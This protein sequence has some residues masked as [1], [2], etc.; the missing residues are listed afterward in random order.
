MTKIS[1]QYSLTNVLTADTTNGRVGINNASPT[2]AL[3]VTGAGRFSGVLN[4]QGSVMGQLTAD[5]GPLFRVVSGATTSTRSGIA[6]K[7]SWNGVTNTGSYVYLFVGTG[8]GERE[9]M[10]IINNGNVGIGTSS[11]NISGGASG[12]IA[13]TISASESGRN[14]IL[15]LKG[16]RTASGQISSYVRSFSN[17]A[18]SP[19]VDLVFYR[20]AADTDGELAIAT[21]GTERMRIT[22]G[23]N[24]GIGTTAD[25]SKLTITASSFP[26]LR[27]NAD[28]GYNA[29]SIGGTGLIRVDY[30]GIGGGRFEINDSGTMFLRL[31]SNGTLSISGGQVVS[32]SDINL[33]IDDGSIENALD[34]ILQLNPRYF[35]WKED[36]G[37][38]TNERQ[39]GFYAQ[40]VQEALGEEVANN[41]NN[42][43][44]GIYDRGIIAMLTKAIQELSAEINI[45][46]NK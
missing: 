36:S 43:K 40:N 32:S 45:L 16:T 10:R 25:T 29:L 34:K 31:Y 24:V 18:T 20:G 44:W 2:V 35:Y 12:S 33:K 26:A 1:N 41:N 42:D 7:D 27:I 15:E 19:G 9:A 17:S 4:I 11:P 37:I 23:G 39:L 3:D 8:S 5:N 28:A 46:K 21:S 30:P 6:I 13:L 14:G 22:S 38:E